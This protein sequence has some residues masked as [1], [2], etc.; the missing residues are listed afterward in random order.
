MY[1]CC[2]ELLQETNQAMQIIKMKLSSHSCLDQDERIYTDK[3][4]TW[5]HED[6]EA[7][8]GVENAYFNIETSKSNGT[9]KWLG[10][11]II[12]TK[13]LMLYKIKDV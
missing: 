6:D 11:L 9:E 12:I 8:D 4:E 1:C 3:H 5:S 13:I 10:S 2:Q 7:K